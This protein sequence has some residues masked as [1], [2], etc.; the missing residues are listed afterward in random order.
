[1]KCA[2]TSLLP[3][4]QTVERIHTCSV[5]P[6]NN[7]LHGHP[8]HPRPCKQFREL[9]SHDHTV[10]VGTDVCPAHL[11]P[12]EF[13]GQKHPLSKG[14]VTWVVCGGRQNTEYL[15]IDCTAVP[16]QSNTFCSLPCRHC[17]GTLKERKNKC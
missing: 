4:E 3:S 15:A 7:V 5:K 8:L 13:R 9:V 17:P 6:S 2:L 11:T 16:Q 12:M 10:R 1:M 14:C